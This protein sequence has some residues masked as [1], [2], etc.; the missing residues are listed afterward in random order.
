MTFFAAAAPA[1]R[2]SVW[3][4]RAVRLRVVPRLSWNVDW[5]FLACVLP[6]TFMYAFVI[7]FDIYI[8]LLKNLI[9][10]VPGAVAAFLAAGR[11]PSWAI[12]ALATY[13][14]FGKIIVGNIGP[15]LNGSNILVMLMLSTIARMAKPAGRGKL[16]LEFVQWAIVL[17]GLWAFLAFIRG[18]SFAH[19]VGGFGLVNHFKQYY[20]P[21][22][23]VI[24]TAALLQDRKD[25]HRV[26]AVIAIT[27]VVVALMGHH[28]YR[29]LTGGSWAEMRIG[30][31]S[32]H[33]NTLAA[34]FIY[35]GLI[36]LALSST[37][38]KQRRLLGLALLLGF[39]ATC[40]GIR[41]T[42]SRGGMLG[43]A[44]GVFTLA[45][46]KDRLLLV[47]LVAGISFALAN[48]AVLPQS[49]RERFASTASGNEGAGS[50]EERVDKSAATR[51]VIWKGAAD[52]IADHPLLGVGFGVFPYFIG[53]YAPDLAKY[54]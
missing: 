33:S 30:G 8:S 14:P 1:I 24:W 35:Y 11:R 18:A 16:E 17:Y 23:A 50:A 44:A 19:S 27:P 48:P 36:L 45:L 34:F 20:S 2:P 13:I 7:T 52:M 54:S 9:L 41:E 32:R 42:Q 21:F 37:F 28:E 12:V 51:I 26:V 29:N 15:G 38:R 5:R 43:L 3:G 53:D 49:V 4:W 31:I 25:V 6:F 22:T 10:I 39:L 47:I 46:I 40:E